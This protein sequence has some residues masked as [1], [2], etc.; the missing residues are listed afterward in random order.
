MAHR[1]HHLASW[2]RTT[3][4]AGLVPLL[5]VTSLPACTLRWDTP[6]PGRPGQ[7]AEPADAPPAAQVLSDWSRVEAVP[8]GTPTEV[9]L[10]DDAAPPDSRR[11]TGRFHAATADTL[12]LTLEEQ[13]TPLRTLAQSAVHIVEVRRPI[14]K[15]SAGWF[16]LGVITAGFAFIALAGS[17]LTLWAPLYF[18]PLYGGPAAL[19]GFFLQRKERIYETPLKAASVPISQVDV[20][21]MLTRAP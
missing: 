7:R 15:R 21:A 12:T 10:Y 4:A 8:V 5:L 3:T 1:F 11:V 18:G 13:S 17:D 19:I 16:A 14:R 2:I 9:H 6:R 20:P